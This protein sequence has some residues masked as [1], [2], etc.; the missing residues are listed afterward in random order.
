MISS[1]RS[2]GTHTALWVRSRRRSQFSWCF[3][4][5]ATIGGASSVPHVWMNGRKRFG[6]CSTGITGG[7]RGSSSRHESIRRG[8]VVVDQWGGRLSAAVLERGRALQNALLRVF[9]PYVQILQES[10]WYYIFLLLNE[11]T[12]LCLTITADIATQLH[13]RTMSISILAQYSPRL[14]S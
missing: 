5:E 9:L 1:V 11:K 13:L 10:H 3:L 7:L 4:Q 6:Q 12:E 2:P 14:K 8:P